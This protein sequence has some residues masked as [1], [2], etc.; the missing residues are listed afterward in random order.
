MNLTE[1]YRPKKLEEVDGHPEVL[2]V[3]RGLLEDHAEQM[4]GDRDR[5]TR[6]TI[7]IT[8]PFGT[9]KTTLAYIIAR[10]LNCKIATAPVV[11]CDPHLE[12]DKLCSSCKNFLHGYVVDIHELN[13]ASENGVNEMRSLQE[14]LQNMPMG[15]RRRI[16]ILDEAQGLTK[17]AWS[18]GLKTL[19]HPPAHA[20]LILCSMAPEAIPEAIVSRAL[21]LKL[22]AISPAT[23]APRLIHI[24]EDQG[25]PRGVFTKEQA[26]KM[27]E[28]SRGHFRSAVVL[29]EKLL[30]S[31]KAA[32]TLDPDRAISKA[33]EESLNQAPLKIAL[34]FVHGM[35]MVNPAGNSA[36]LTLATQFGQSN[37]EEFINNVLFV[38]VNLMRF[39]SLP[40]KVDTSFNDTI[41]L[42]NSLE[43]KPVRLPLLLPF[44]K[45]V[46]EAY[47]QRRSSLLPLDMVIEFMV[48]EVY[49]A[50]LEVV[51]A[52]S[53]QMDDARFA[54][55]G[56]IEQLQVNSA[57]KGLTINKDDKLGRPVFTVLFSGAKPVVP[58]M[59]QGYHVVLTEVK[60]EVQ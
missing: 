54:S 18:A 20:V 39:T 5:E 37:P 19:E 10:S 46:R 49:M 24:A 41:R 16:F 40:S 21:H 25:V 17:A 2:Q 59:Y 57:Y 51:S 15:G 58:K 1:V 32:G 12:A 31:F 7:L 48:N 47:E 22:H 35:L 6:R 36:A 50:L 14:Q 28:A 44:A 56:L 3:I 8:G 27:A 38:L 11:P 60:P 4:R 53:R 26:L 33:L 43:H 29:M 30:Y 9:G 55:R 42:L 34:K 52:E 45:K 23:M 13:G